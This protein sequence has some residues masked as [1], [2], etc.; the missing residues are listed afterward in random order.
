MDKIFVRVTAGEEVLETSK[1]KDS[2]T[3]QP[4]WK[5]DHLS[6][7]CPKSLKKIKIEVINEN[8][9]VGTHECDKRLFIVPDEESEWK[10][11]LMFEGKEIGEIKFN[12][13]CNSPNIVFKEVTGDYK[14]KLPGA[15]DEKK[16][17]EEEEKNKE[18]E[19]KKKKEEEEEEEERK[20]KEEEE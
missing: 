4:V 3:D 14:K 1:S 2:K 16:K 10:E 19:E 6:F 9:V 12:S 11:E 18:E 17:K 7:T 20:K 15:E 5:D 8:E 13:R